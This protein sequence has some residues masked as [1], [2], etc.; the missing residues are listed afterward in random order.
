ME[1]W[2]LIACIAPALWAIVN[3]ID[4]YFVE[5]VYTDEYDGAIISG[6]FQVFPWILVGVGLWEFEFSSAGAWYLFAAGACFSWSVFFYFR[7]LFSHNDASLIQILWNLAV[8][9]T[10]FLAWFF[11][12]AALIPYQYVGVL[13]ILLGVSFLNFRNTFTW[14]SI[15]ALRKPMFFAVIFLS[16][17]F[18]FSEQ[19]YNASTTSFLNSYLIFALGNIFAAL[20]LLS[21]KFSESLKRLQHISSLSKKYFLVFLGAEAIALVGTIFSQRAL[22][23]A[24]SAGLVATVESLSPVFVM[25]FS[26]L[27]LATLY[28]TNRRSKVA[29]QVYHDQLQGYWVKIA[30][31]FIIA[32][33]IYCLSLS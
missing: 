18:L 32:I 5:S 1:T 9:L 26:A 2:L 3:L 14:S 31:S 13:I 25:A 4:V 29:H 27:L 22:D 30:S 23:I 11:Y 6:L 10:L 28:V 19:G 21:I 8:P 15:W 33:G 16:I 12:D 24:P 20:V 7:A 17:N